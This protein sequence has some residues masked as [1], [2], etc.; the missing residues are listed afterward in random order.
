MSTYQ[1][2]CSSTSAH[3]RA[4]LC[5]QTQEMLPKVNI[6]RCYKHQKDELATPQQRPSL[7]VYEKLQ[8]LPKCQ[9]RVRI[10]DNVYDRLPPTSSLR[11]IPKKQ[12]A[13][14]YLPDGVC[15]HGMRTNNP[16]EVFNA[17]ALG[18]R[19]Q[20]TLYRSML[21]TVQL[22]QHRRQALLRTIPPV[23]S[24]VGGAPSTPTDQS[25]GVEVQHGPPEARGEPPRVRDAYAKSRAKA[26]MLAT[27]VVCDDP[28]GLSSQTFMIESSAGGALTSL[29]SSSLLGGGFK[30]PVSIA[31]YLNGDFE[32]ACGCGRSASAAAACH[33]VLRVVMACRKA[34]LLSFRKP[35]QVRTEG[36]QLHAHAN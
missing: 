26:S 10:A 23:A 2:V 25:D 29:A 3:T 17:M 1:R 35:W 19:Q 7:E 21:A 20:E 15:T 34:D 13:P 14:V 4:S 5:V 32:G 33:H 27:P 22:L 36:T 12:L 11:K 6:L 18:V 9:N 30:W 31:K 16:A 8:A 28:E 24:K